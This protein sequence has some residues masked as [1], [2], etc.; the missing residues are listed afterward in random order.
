MFRSDHL[1]Y[2]FRF[3]LVP[4][5]GLWFDHCCHHCADDCDLQNTEVSVQIGMCECPARDC[6]VD[7]TWIVSVYRLSI[8]TVKAVFLE[9]RIRHIV[10]SL[11]TYWGNRPRKSANVCIV[12]SNSQSTCFCMLR[13]TRTWNVTSK[14][15]G[16]ILALKAPWQPT[17]LHWASIYQ[18]KLKKISMLTGDFYFLPTSSVDY[19]HPGQWLLETKRKPLLKQSR[20]TVLSTK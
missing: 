4:G 14:T 20:M 19:P 10:C 13:S 18:T 12:Y 15:L 2:N 5:V 8:L 6:S 9:S 3:L 7:F 16:H 1:A 17:L 11:N